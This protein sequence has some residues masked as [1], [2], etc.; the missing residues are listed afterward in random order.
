[1]CYSE[2]PC[3]NCENELIC[4]YYGIGAYSGQKKEF[5]EDFWLEHQREEYEEACKMRLRKERT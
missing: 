3:L 5:D 1:M 2:N 4:D